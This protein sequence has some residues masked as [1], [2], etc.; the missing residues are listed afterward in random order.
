MHNG[1]PL[2]GHVVDKV[3]FSRIWAMQ[4]YMK[5]RLVV[6]NLKMAWSG[7]FIP[8]LF[9]FSLFVNRISLF[10]NVADKP[11]AEEISKKKKHVADKPMAEEISKRFV[12]VRRNRTGKNSRT[13]KKGTSL[14]IVR[15]TW[16]QKLAFPKLFF[17]LFLTSLSRC[18]DIKYIT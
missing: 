6:Q 12:Y 1:K 5:R 8:K 2:S 15:V 10:E 18:L 13:R 7:R 9:D 3:I 14:T 16:T 11:M 4:Q 17:F